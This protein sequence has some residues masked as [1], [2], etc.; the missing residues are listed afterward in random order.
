VPENSDPQASETPL[1]T[2]PRGYVL[3]PLEE[4]RLMAAAFY[5]PFS[6]GPPAPDLGSPAPDLEEADSLP[7]NGTIVTDIGLGEQP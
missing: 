7:Y 2:I 6:G 4:F 1:F 5:G 3:L